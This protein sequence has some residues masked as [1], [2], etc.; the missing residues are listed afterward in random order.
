MYVLVNAYGEEVWS[1]TRDVVVKGVWWWVECGWIVTC[2][3]LW[4]GDGV[5]TEK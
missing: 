3:T 4:C 5:H 2:D 1:G